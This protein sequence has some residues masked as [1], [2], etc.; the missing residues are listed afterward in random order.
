MILTS[1]KD[2][3]SP[4]IAALATRLD[5]TRPAVSRSVKALREDGLVVRTPGIGWVLAD[6]GR[7]EFDA[8]SAQLVKTTAVASHDLLKRIAASQIAG[9]DDTTI[10]QFQAMS[11][12]FAS[13]A[14]L[15]RLMPTLDAPIFQAL[16]DT[17]KFIAPYRIAAQVISANVP[18]QKS[19]AALVADMSQAQGITAQLAQSLSS[20]ELPVAL[21]V[22]SA[23]S[24]GIAN[25]LTDTKYISQLMSAVVSQATLAAP[26]PRILAEWRLAVNRY[27]TLQE[28]RLHLASMAKHVGALQ[29]TL[30]TATLSAYSRSVRCYVN[31][32]VDD[33][34]LTEWQSEVV[35]ADTDTRGL[36]EQL[37]PLLAKVDSRLVAKRR[38]IW[39]AL[40]GHND[41]GPCQAAHS[42][43][44][45]LRLT[46]ATLAPDEMFR[47]D[48]PTR[49][50][51]VAYLLKSKSHAEYIDTMAGA[52]NA[53]YGRLS[54]RAHSLEQARLSAIA[55]VTASE[56]LLL[57]V[58]LAAQD[59]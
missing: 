13:V 42:A 24:A 5:K 37:E 10:R 36:G 58:L 23:N 8:V 16:A 1:L 18:W 20:L 2:N 12:Q 14:P 48:S 50:Q 44:E 49:R 43:R 53:M 59:S 7:R 34:P 29:L 3:P 30:P 46:L 51:R 22:M 31:T 28:D 54:N 45:L 57:D 35:A 17:Q 33:E 38:G 25:M 56:A 21:T 41:D 4:T 47:E 52:I 39:D 6:A 27:T 26:I 19:L 40:S 9:L 32:M 11:K 15:V 55:I